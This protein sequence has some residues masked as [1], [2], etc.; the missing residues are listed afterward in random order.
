MVVTPLYAG[1]LA[2]WLLV[3]ALRVIQ[4]RKRARA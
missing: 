2:I 1:L 3:L 4:H